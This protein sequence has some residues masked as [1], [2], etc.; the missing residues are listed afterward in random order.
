MLLSGVEMGKLF[1]NFRRSAFRMETRQVYTMEAEQDE[2]RQF[3]SGEPIPE[4]FNAGWHDEVR[5]NVEAGKTMTRL[6]VVRR[7]FTD[8]TWFLFEWAI[9]GNV[10]AGE[11]YRILDVTDSELDIPS[12]D[13]WLFDDEA[14]ALLNFN[15][16]GTL[17]NRE[18]V[19]DVEPYLE[20]RDVALRESVPFG[21][22][23]P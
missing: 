12:Q 7:P 9:P 16:D 20:W 14:V 4:G 18:L 13:F 21:D 22:Y 19:Q 10:D 17:K 15:E 23:R 1:D 11:D 5:G 6:K 2:I 8:Y 3:L